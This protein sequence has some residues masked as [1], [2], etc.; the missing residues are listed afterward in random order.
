MGTSL[1]KEDVVQLSNTLQENAD[2]FAWTAAD[3]PGVNPDH[4]HT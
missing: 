1:S 3:I 4:Y 2:V